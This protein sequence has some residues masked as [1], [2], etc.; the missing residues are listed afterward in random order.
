M[1]GGIDAIGN[2]AS[3][4]ALGCHSWAP[5]IKL[6]YPRLQKRVSLRRPI[7]IVHSECQKGSQKRLAMFTSL[8]TALLVI[9]ILFPIIA[10]CALGLR[11]RARHIKKVP[12]GLDDWTLFLGLMFAYMDNFTVAYGVYNSGFGVP[13]NKIMGKI[14]VAFGKVMSLIST[15][16]DLL[17]NVSF[18]VGSFHRNAMLASCDGDDQS[19]NLTALSAN[20]RYQTLS[21]CG[22][23]AYCH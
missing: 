5:L 4:I 15:S 17:S 20:I 22:A 14:Q 19:L 11:V 21:L 12:L 9:S 10:T 18:Q 8:G 23:C 16:N 2:Q 13:Q 7:L 3:P 1:V 6:A